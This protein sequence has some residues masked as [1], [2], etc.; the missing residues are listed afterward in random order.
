[1]FYVLCRVSGGYTG[2]HTALL[3]SNGVVQQFDT[4]EAAE[5]EARR[6]NRKMNNAYSVA[7]FHYRAI[8]DVEALAYYG[9]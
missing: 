6:L 9:F 1:M 7:D 5:N 8:D 2:T 3:K 4:R